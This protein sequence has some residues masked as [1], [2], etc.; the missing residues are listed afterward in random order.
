MQPTLA[1]VED[2]ARRA[3][4]ILRENFHPRP[5]FGPQLL[6][7]FKSETDPVTEV[8][9]RIEAFL[10]E[11]IQGHFPDHQII[12]EESGLLQGNLDRQWFLDPLDGTVNFTHG[13]PIFVVSI[14]YARKGKVTLGAVYDPMLGECF[15]AERGRG[16]W[17]NGEPIR[18]SV[19]QDLGRG[20]VGTGFPYD[21]RTDPIN[22]L[23]NYTTATMLA[24]AVRHMGAAAR[25]LCY[26]AAG[27]LD[28]FWELRL[29]P[30]D[31]AAGGL[32]AEEAGAIVSKVTGDPQYMLIP[33]SILAANPHLHPRILKFLNQ[34]SVS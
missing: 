25:D 32:I 29:S 14:A 5:G 3:G 10:L 8:D 6:V 19:T 21:V 2:L 9:H 33:N 16:A 17:L 4:A 18:V 7:K 22:N 13:V 15:S 24:Q 26:V 30:W 20:L 12:T 34:N 23:D 11:E 1:D 31:I 28:A 27:R